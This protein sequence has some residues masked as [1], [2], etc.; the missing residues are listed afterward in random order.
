MVC[1]PSRVLEGWSLCCATCARAFCTPH[2]AKAVLG[3]DP[4]GLL[5]RLRVKDGIAVSEP[6]GVRWDRNMVGEVFKTLKIVQPQAG[7]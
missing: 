7:A 5:Y 1:T 6:S 3:A 2:P 4:R